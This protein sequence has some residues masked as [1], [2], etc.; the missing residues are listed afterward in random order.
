MSVNRS[1]ALVGFLLIAGIGLI[2]LPILVPA[3]VPDNRVEFYVEADWSDRAEQPTFAY[4]NFSEGE[5]DI[6]DQARQTT[7]GTINR[8]I[9]SAPDSLTPP[10]DSIEIFNVRY[11]GEIYL[12]QVRY[13]TYDADFMTQQLPRLGFLAGGIACLVAV[14]YWRFE[15]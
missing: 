12:F 4:T 8:S 10:P 14:A 11:E 13:L 15:R 9:S 6:F 7:P 2:A 1:S 5:R 3:D